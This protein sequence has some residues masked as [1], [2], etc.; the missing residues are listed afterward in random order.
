MRLGQAHGQSKDL[1][2]RRRYKPS[3]MMMR[4]MLGI[5]PT[6]MT[7]AM[8]M[9]AMTRQSPTMTAMV[10]STIRAANGTASGKIPMQMSPQIG[11]TMVKPAVAA[12]TTKRAATRAQGNTETRE[13]TCGSLP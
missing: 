4:M 11:A 7:I 9:A 10:M 1:L 8:S 2:S 12:P 6:T 3:L 5:G 13:N